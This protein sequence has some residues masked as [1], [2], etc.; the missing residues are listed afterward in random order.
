MSPG[1]CDAPARPHCPPHALTG[2]LLGV[3]R[4]A[5]TQMPRLSTEARD[6]IRCGGPDVVWLSRGTHPLAW[7]VD[8]FPRR[9]PAL[10]CGG[11]P[12]ATEENAGFRTV[13][14]RSAH[15]KIPMP[16]FPRL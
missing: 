13:S 11:R 14:P 10:S 1:V 9:L 3:L 16:Q 6:R 5:L 7:L 2:P 8:M 15:S 12:M 4:L